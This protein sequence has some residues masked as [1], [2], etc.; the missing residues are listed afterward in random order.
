[1]SQL[2][3]GRTETNMFPEVESTWKV[4]DSFLL[5]L[6]TDMHTFNAKTCIYCYSP[7]L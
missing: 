5:F 2:G 4:C 7:T 6:N 3:G 1:M